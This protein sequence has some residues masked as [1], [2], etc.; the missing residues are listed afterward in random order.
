MVAEE[1]LYHLKLLF[2]RGDHYSKT[3]EEGKRKRGERKIDEER[4]AGF[5][6][7]C[8]W[9][10]SEL[11]HGVMTLDQLH[12]KLQEFDQSPDKSLLFKVLAKDKTPREI[13]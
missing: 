3:E 8:E 1:T 7:F 6:E 10:D 9:Y 2:E 13:P 12:E 5:I 11:E 4:E